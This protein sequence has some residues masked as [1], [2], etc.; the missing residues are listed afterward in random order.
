MSAS[1]MTQKHYAKA[2]IVEAAI[3]VRCVFASEQTLEQLDPIQGLLAADYPSSREDQV[4]LKAQITPAAGF[5]EE[6]KASRA[7]AS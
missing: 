2:P 4:Q 7:I 3:D 5:T 1:V 6:H